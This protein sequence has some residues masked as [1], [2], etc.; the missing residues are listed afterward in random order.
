LHT[1]PFVQADICRLRRTDELVYPAFLAEGD[2]FYD[3]RQSL[4]AADD[5]GPSGG[6][7]K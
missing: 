6:L 1:R 7:G 3:R 4:A 5:T 2:A